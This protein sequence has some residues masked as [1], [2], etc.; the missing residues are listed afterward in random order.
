MGLTPQ[1]EF[2]AHRRVDLH[3]N[4][5]CVFR[6]LDK[7]I[8]IDVKGLALREFE[9]LDLA[10]P[11]KEQL[12]HHS[13]VVRVN[14]PGLYEHSHNVAL[15]F[16]LE[17]LDP[18]A[19]VKILLHLGESA[20]RKIINF[21]IYYE[22]YK[23]A[24][25]GEAQHVID[26]H[27]LTRGHNNGPLF[28]HRLDNSRE[29]ALESVYHSIREVSGQDAR[30]LLKHPQRNVWIGGTGLQPSPFLGPSL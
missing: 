24:M 11:G 12:I 7:S 13:A 2:G 25:A 28:G 17:H 23:V 29:V 26:F 16:G 8:H 14:V 9:S 19:F 1:S 4:T 10:N 20:I 18:K 3:G 30:M 22:G 15:A 6:K 27:S 21:P 5:H